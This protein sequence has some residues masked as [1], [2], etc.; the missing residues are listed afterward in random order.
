[1]NCVAIDSLWKLLGPLR[2]AIREVLKGGLN[3]SF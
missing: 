3:G 2:A 1:M